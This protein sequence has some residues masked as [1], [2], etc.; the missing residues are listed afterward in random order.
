MILELEHDLECLFRVYNADAPEAVIF[1]SA[2]I[3]EGLMVEVNPGTSRRHQ[4]LYNCL[5]EIQQRGL[6]RHT[7]MVFAH[8]FT[9]HGQGSYALDSFQR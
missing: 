9:L 4:P 5:R 2:R 6:M 8:A 1:Y 7:Q 3:L